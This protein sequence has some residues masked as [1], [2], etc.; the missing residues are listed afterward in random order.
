MERATDRLLSE[1]GR[2][3]YAK[4]LNDPI[5]LLV[6]AALEE[7]SRSSG[8]QGVA[9]ATDCTYRYGF[10]SGIQFTLDRMKTLPTSLA[11]VKATEEPKPQYTKEQ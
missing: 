9:D 2:I 5:T 8:V 7:N 11:G 10:L 6:I 3:E 1:Q 4:W